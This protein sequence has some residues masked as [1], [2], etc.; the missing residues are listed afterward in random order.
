MGYFMNSTLN[1]LKTRRIYSVGSMGIYDHQ[2][3]IYWKISI[4][5]TLSI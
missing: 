2:E 5:P 3:G 1:I 4:K